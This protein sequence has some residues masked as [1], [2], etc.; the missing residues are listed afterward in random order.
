[1]GFNRDQIPTREWVYREEGDEREGISL[2]SDG[3]VFWADIPSDEM[4]GGGAY[5]AGFREFLRNLRRG[6]PRYADIPPEILE[7]IR[8]ILEAAQKR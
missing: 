1:M 6:E 4:F 2:S 7:E 8:Q 5:R 3:V